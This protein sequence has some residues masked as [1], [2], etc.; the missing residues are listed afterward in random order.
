ME[1]DSGNVL[2]MVSYPSY[3]NN[4]FSGSIDSETWNTLSS[5]LSNP[6]FGR[7]TK[8]RV[9]P[10][11]TLK[12]LSAIAG[13]ETGVISTGTYINCAG[14]F[15]TITP[16][17][18]CWIYPGGHGGL[19]VTG[20]IQNSCNVF[21]Y[22]VGYRLSTMNG[23]YNE[24]EG[25]A[26]LRKYGE[27]MGLTS[28][29]GVEVEE[30]EPSFSDVYPIPSMIGQGSHSYVSTQLARY[31]NCIASKGTNYELTLIKKIKDRD[32]EEKELPEKSVKKIEASD[33]TINSIIEG[34]R[35]AATTYPRVNALNLNAAAKSG[36]SQE[37][38]NLP[39]HA[40]MVSFAPADD[41]VLSMS[42]MIQNGYVSA[43]AAA[44]TADIMDFVFKKTTLE[45][46]LAGNADGPADLSQITDDDDDSSN[47]D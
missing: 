6:L 34:M 36:T 9:P 44:L 12:P 18:K 15:K 19:E 5:D 30:Y 1:P 10:G 41:P 39:D 2:A 8:M 22:E 26:Q 28:K 11:S 45:Q 31:V 27:M 21:F 47:E 32:G 37:N 23:S 35:K 46:I 33:E 14:L 3:D 25:L 24:Q 43:N 17:P 20:A 29:S 16:S 4:S 38:A 40:L 7:A 42:V 13:L